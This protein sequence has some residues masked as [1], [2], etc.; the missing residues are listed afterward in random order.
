MNAEPR[1]LSSAQTFVMKFIFPVGWIGALTLFTLT[2]F[3]SSGQDGQSA[4]ANMKWFFLLLT[5]VGPVVIW[6]EGCVRVKRV[7]MDAR[8]LYISN[9]STEI[10]VPLTNVAEVSENRWLDIHFDAF[11][12]PVTIQFQSDT[13]TIQFHS[14]TEFGSQVTFMPKTRWFAS[15]SSHP[16]VEEIRLA[17]DR[18]T[19]R[20]RG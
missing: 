16:V 15:W 2:L 18:A 3:L 13:V 1:T 5:I 8:A 7:R 20:D 11:V 14:D 9:Y 10:T 17:A 12:T 4:V 19:G 6:W